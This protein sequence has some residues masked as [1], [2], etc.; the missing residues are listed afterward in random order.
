MRSRQRMAT[1]KNFYSI[2]SGG[3]IRFAL[4]K[5]FFISFAFLC[6]NFRGGRQY[7]TVFSVAI[8]I[9]VVKFNVVV[10]LAAF[11]AG[12]FCH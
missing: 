12:E 5:T 4:E 7:T 1:G 9:V 2:K 8:V 6:V 3:K 10:N 11:L